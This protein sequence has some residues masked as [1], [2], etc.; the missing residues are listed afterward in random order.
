MSCRSHRRHQRG[1]ILAF[2]GLTIVPVA[3][4]LI[5]LAV[6]V[7]R[8]AFTASEVQALAD[9]TALA[10]A[11]AVSRGQDAVQAAQ[12]NA[13]TNFVDGRAASIATADVQVGVYTPA[14][15]V[16]VQT[17]VAANAVRTTPHVTVNTI[18]ASIYSR[19]PTQALTKTAIAMFKPLTNSYP[20]L[21][22]VVGQC[23]FQQF[24]NTNDC[25]TLP[26]LSQVPNGAD[27]SAWTSLSPTTSASSSNVG[28][29]LPASCGGS[30]APPPELTINESIQITNGQAT[31]ST[32]GNIANCVAAGMDT[33]VIPIVPCTP[34]YNQA[35]PIQGFATIRITRVE[36]S[37]S[38]KGLYLSAICAT[39]GTTVGSGSAGT[40]FG[41]GLVRLVS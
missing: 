18:L 4:G 1:S 9:S 2:A 21:P 23:N 5:V 29:L 7:A 34:N 37:G 15:G 36:T 20:V 14:T 24:L 11:L 19:T 6:D 31:Q 13:V 39:S 40:N 41:T 22:I 17:N 3:F 27:N 35:L 28:A 26:T 30:G 25:S 10:G 16:F 12:G 38:A 32:L 33:F 8:I